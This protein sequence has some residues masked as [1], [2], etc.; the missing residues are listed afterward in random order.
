MDPEKIAAIVDWPVPRTVKDILSFLGFA[1]FYRMFIEGFGR[2]AVPLT[3]MTKSD[4]KFHWTA[5]CQRAFKELKTRFTT[6]PILIHFNPELETWVEVDASDLVV[7]GI[8]SQMSDGN[9]RPVAFFS[10]K[11]SPAECNYEIYD[12]ELLAIIKAFEEW[13]PELAGT[14]PSN[15]IKV[16]SDHRSLEYFMTT[17]QLNRR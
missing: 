13:R 6:A 12:K 8:L 7:A 10:K 5:D 1:N 2:V 4:Q 16:L 17:K 14:D 9:L 15:P 3:N 11:M